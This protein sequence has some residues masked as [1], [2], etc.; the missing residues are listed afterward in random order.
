VCW[1]PG[2]SEDAEVPMSLDESDDGMRN[3][4]RGGL[5]GG[6]ALPPCRTGGKGA[7]EGEA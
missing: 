2:S 6:A 3:G 4:P 7:E 1:E 5:A